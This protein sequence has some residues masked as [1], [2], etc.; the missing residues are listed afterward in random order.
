[1]TVFVEPVRTSRTFEAA[2]ENLLEGIERAA[3]HLDDRL[4]TEE[5][6]AGQLGIS[7]P[8]LRQA[9]RVLER[10]GLVRVRAGKGGGIFMASDV[11]PVD[12]ISH[13]VA[14]EA[15]DAVDVLRAR[16]LLEGAVTIMAA[17]AATE[18]DYAA[19]ERTVDL[20]ARN[21][22]DRP[23]IMGLNAMFHRA[24]IR[25]C[26]NKTLQGAMRNIEADL[27]PIRDSY[28]GGIENDRETLEIH[29]RQLAAM[30]SGDLKALAAVLDEHFRTLEEEFA[31]ALHRRWETLFG[32]VAEQTLRLGAPV[33]KS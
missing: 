7:K 13:N 25:A 22:G 31:T 33:R 28:Q 30:R 10:S 3:L 9:L 24:V 23:R 17:K 16:R 19:I 29:R 12:A 15:E 18:D 14:V 21:I 4:P 5:Q 20:L 27:A 2:I 11:V 32:E 26:H 8:T 1:M 6:L